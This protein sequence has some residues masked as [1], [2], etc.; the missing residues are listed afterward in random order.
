MDF[1]LTAEQVLLR[2]TT[3]DLLAMHP[4]RGGASLDVWHQLADVGVLG[5][6]LC[7][8]DGGAGGGPVEVQVV[9]TEI[10]RALAP[11]PLIDAVLTPGALVSAAA[12]AEQR[13]RLLP[14]VATGDRMLAFAHAPTMPTTATAHGNTWTLDGHRLAV[15][16]GDLADDLVISAALPGGG[17][18]LFLVDAGA[19]ARQP[20]RTFDGRSGAR[21]DLQTTPAEPLGDPTDASVHIGAATVYSQAALCAEACGAMAEVLRLT[22]EYLKARKQFGV[23]LS[24]FQALTQRAADMYIS[25]E[26]AR[27]MS[28]YATMSLA[29]G[30]VDPVVA[31]RA[32]LQIGRAAR[33]IAQESIQLHGGIGLT[34]EYPAG[35]YAAR[36]TAIEHTLGST[37]DHLR[38][39]TAHTKEYPR[40]EL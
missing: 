24:S 37:D 34:D 23:P 28:L 12:T 1:E 29:D 38:I 10:G 7:E 32:K 31:S 3:R 19:V 8:D 36:L 39:L 35:H 4:A 33:H 18:G 22:T 25:L 11:E 40:V 15:P 6:T 9:M 13:K 20:Y 21:I 17:T 5:L 26:L 14:D 2:D 30:T 27:S 16:S